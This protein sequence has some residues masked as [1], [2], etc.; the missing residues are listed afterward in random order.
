MTFRY[1]RSYQGPLQAVVLDWAGTTVD[2]GCLAPAAIFREAFAAHG[3][4]ITVAQAR[5]P[6]RSREGASRSAPGSTG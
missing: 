2:H 5:A 6:M 1:H 3:V 4:D